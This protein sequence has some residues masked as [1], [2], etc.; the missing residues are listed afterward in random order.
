MPWV[1]VE[2]GGFLARKLGSQ[3]PQGHWE[4]AME[5]SSGAQLCE[6]V[7]RLAQVEG[8]FATVISDGQGLV[9]EVLLLVNGKLK[10]WDGAARVKLCDGDRVQFYPMIGGG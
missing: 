3:D 8:R 10:D 5:F 2:V 7:S 4:R 1:Q 6:I 9:P